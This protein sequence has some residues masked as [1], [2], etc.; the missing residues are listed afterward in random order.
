MELHS[1]HFLLVAGHG[2]HVQRGRAADD[3][4]SGRR[5]HD[6]VA[7]AH[8]DL[9]RLRQAFPQRGISSQRQFGRAVF[10]GLGTGKLSAEAVSHKL[11]AVADAEHRHTEFE[12]PLIQGRSILA[13]DAGRSAGKDDGLRL[14]S[15]HVRR[16]HVAGMNFRINAGFAHAAGNELR[17]L[18]AV[19]DDNDLVGH[20]ASLL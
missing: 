10:T 5:G 4:E 20:M 8:P 9:R 2:S 15:S 16:F 11:H 17:H 14:H 13:A 6:L 7:V 18:R 12:Q 19:V 1:V 3:A